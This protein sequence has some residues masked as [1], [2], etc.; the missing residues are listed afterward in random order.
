MPVYNS[1]KYIV[2]ALF[3]VLKQT[4][5]DFEFIIIDDA[6]TDNSTKLIKNIKDTRIKLYINELNRGISY[7][8]NRGL[9]I[10][11]GQYIA[12]MDSDDICAPDRFKMQLEFMDNN[13]MTDICGTNI[14]LINNTGD[15]I[16]EHTYSSIDKN[17]KTDL[18]FGMT[19]LAHSSVM[20]RK[21]FVDK[22]GLYY[23][24]GAM[25]AEDYDL[26]CRYCERCTFSNIPE[27]L[28]YYRQHNLSVSKQYKKIQ[29]LNARQSLKKHLSNM[30]LKCSEIE[31][32]SHCS[33]Y[34]PMQTDNVSYKDI[35]N[36]IDLL[37]TFNAEKKFFDNDYFT[38]NIEKWT[39]K[40]SRR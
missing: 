3:S 8:L 26:Y 40:L 37:R 32:Q 4:Y 33:F 9:Q 11:K 14:A 29:R 21:S 17:I 39:Y 27:T 16:N 25:Y 31:F 24:N 19:P 20:F 7:S 13:P 28:L 10:C 22:Y 38:Y 36:W 6:S 35:H 5:D 2:D 1:E 18:F 30:G 34:L 15:F 23:K 12:R